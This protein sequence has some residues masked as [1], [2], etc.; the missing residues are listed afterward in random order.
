MLGHET[1]KTRPALGISNDVAKSL[2]ITV[3]VAAVSRR[4]NAPHLIQ[5]R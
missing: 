2:A 1:P 3:I 5:I 4:V